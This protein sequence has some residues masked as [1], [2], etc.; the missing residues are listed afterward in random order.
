MWKILGGLLLYLVEPIVAKIAG[1]FTFGLVSYTGIK[2]VYD[3]LDN[4][5][6]GLSGSVGH[7]IYS[8]LSLMGFGDVLAVNMAALLIRSYLDGVN[9]AGS[10]IR[11]RF[12]ATKD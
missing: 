6:I 10:M 12:G 3:Q 11:S 8:I 2:I 7:D 4:M 1:A 5:L 9:S